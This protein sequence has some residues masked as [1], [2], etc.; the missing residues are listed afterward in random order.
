VALLVQL[1][2][3]AGNILAYFVAGA[4][5]LYPRSSHGSDTALILPS[6]QMLPMPGYHVFPILWISLMNFLLVISGLL[7]P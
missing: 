2:I 4:Q 6:V 1:G 7:P 3:A 5:Q